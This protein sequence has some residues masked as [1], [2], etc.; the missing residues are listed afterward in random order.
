MIPVSTLGYAHLSLHHIYASDFFFSPLRIDLM[1]SLMY[2]CTTDSMPQ[3]LKTNIYS[4]LLCV[5]K[6]RLLMFVNNTSALYRN[7]ERKTL[8]LSSFKKK[9]WN[10]THAI[11][12]SWALSTLTKCTFHIH[13]NEMVILGFF[14]FPEILCAV[15]EQSVLV[16]K[17]KQVLA[18][19]KQ[20]KRRTSHNIQSTLILLHKNEILAS[21][22]QNW[23]FFYTPLKKRK[24][25]KLLWV[26][27]KFQ[28]SPALSS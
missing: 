24:L 9:S 1:C 23:P 18:S 17:E 25:C 26:I 10:C 8:F 19:H 27:Y 13:Y 5:K 28:G 22:E 3:G 2:E 15:F 11:V 6:K 12:S 4:Q 7:Q 14:H 20:A 16:L 21:S